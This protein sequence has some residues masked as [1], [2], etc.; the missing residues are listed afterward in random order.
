MYL[1][2]ESSYPWTNQL[3][4]NNIVM[5]DLERNKEGL[6]MVEVDVVLK[7]VCSRFEEF[8]KHWIAEDNLK[9]VQVLCKRLTRFSYHL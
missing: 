9:V 3:L 1:V 6:I 8:C 2:P 7:A 4:K 5:H